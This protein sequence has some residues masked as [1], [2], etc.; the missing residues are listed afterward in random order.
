M[1]N[2]AAVL[3]FFAVAAAAQPVDIKVRRQSESVARLDPSKTAIIICDMWDKHWCRGA[4]ERVG[5]LV[6]RMNPVLIKA[7][8]RGILIIHAPS[9][10][11]DFYKDAPQRLAMLKVPKA[12]PSPVLDVP[13]APLPIDDKDGGCDTEGDS[14]YKAWKREHPGLTIG[15]GDLISD[16]GAE[17]YS[18]LKQRAIE[19]LL[20][21][22]V[23]TNMCILNRTFAIKQMT[24]WGVKCILVRDL[25]DA[26]Y[27]P[28]DAPH[29][30]HSRG[31]ELVVEHIE[32]YWCP[33]MTS[34]DLVA[35][36]P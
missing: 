31:T 15:P 34:Q 2:P 17:V 27:D 4:T 25:T 5:A 19:T 32:K 8:A 11:M 16:N 18:A 20:V 36:L 10:T 21:M 30:P 9:E 23:H 22:G 7:R 35:A 33:T 1:R 12:I 26:M 14:F 3:L 28:K 29:V 13:D 24:R 6:E